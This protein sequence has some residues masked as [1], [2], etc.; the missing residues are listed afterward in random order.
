MR[1]RQACKVQFYR[2]KPLGPYVVDFYAP[3]P[4]LVIEVDGAQHLDADGLAAD[5]ARDEFLSAQGLCVLRFNNRQILRELDHVMEHVY[6]IV[7]DRLNL[8]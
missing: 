3:I 7:R 4:K 1:R 5:Q 2:Q 6:R 8:R